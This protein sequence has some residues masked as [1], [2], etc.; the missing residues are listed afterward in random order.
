MADALIVYAAMACPG[1]CFKSPLRS[2]RFRRQLQ[3]GAAAAGTPANV[4]STTAKAAQAEVDAAAAAVIAAAAAPVPGPCMGE[5][6][7]ARPA[8]TLPDP[9]LVGLGGGKDALFKA[10]PLA[11]VRI[12]VFK[13]VR[14][15]QGG[16]G[17]GGGGAGG[18]AGG[19]AKGRG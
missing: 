17:G 6:V 10:K 12:G 13:E 4:A 18:R 7:A 9:M 11:G 14:G 16:G 19:R 3:L 5:N 2:V 15:A 8:L 1:G